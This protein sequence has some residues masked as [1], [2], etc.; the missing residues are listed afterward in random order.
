MVFVTNVFWERIWLHLDVE[1]D[2]SALFAASP[3]FYLVGKG[4]LV[5]TELQATMLDATHAR[6]RMNVT[7]TGVN[8]CVQNGTYKLMAAAS[9]E[10][11]TAAIE[12]A[13]VEDRELLR[14]FRT[15]EE[16]A[17][18]SRNFNYWSNKGTYTVTF[19]LDEYAEEPE[20]QLLF[21]NAETRRVPHVPPRTKPKDRRASGKKPVKGRL[22]DKLSFLKN[23]QQQVYEFLHRT[24]PRGKKRVLFLSEQDDRLALNMQALYDRMKARGLDREL[25]IEFSLRKATSRQYS[26]MSAVKRTRKIARADV[27]L[28][29]D[30]VPLFDKLVLSRD[31]AVIQVWHAGAGFK[32][33]GYSR[34][35]HH[36]CP[37]PFCCHRQYTWCISGSSYIS[38]FFSE[39]F[40]ILDEQIIPTGMPRM[41]RFLDPE[42]RTAVTA[43]IYETYPALQGRKV[44]LF[45]PTYRGRDKAHA[46][47]PYSLI[48]F[49][50]LYR[51]C[52]EED[53]AV[54]FKMHPWV[55]GSVPIPEDFRGRFLDVNGYPDI[56]ELFYV[57]DLLITDY[58]SSMYEFLLMRKPMLFFAYDKNQY[59]NSRGFHRDYDSNVPG[60]ICETFEALMEALERRDFQ[61]E[62]VEEA[63]GRYFDRT[64]TGSCDRVIDWLILDRLPEEYRE[65]LRRKTAE[66]ERVRQMK[67]TPTRSVR[68]R[69]DGRV[70]EDA[71]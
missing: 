40:G 57:T 14:C 11:E 67:L 66:V 39:Q 20:L 37:G 4:G 3:R 34:W 25:E 43:R 50:R 55:S 32:G 28:V 52:C 38:P 12:H 5:E 56:N 15:A 33:V 45:A 69:E 19:M 60:R 30:H 10:V 13:R 54:L 59:A 7:N 21:Y 62:K 48:D 71:N 49:E 65:A 9:F 44:I 17:V 26:A 23:R 18:W 70:P 46:H 51:F 42:N 41:D 16:L 58:S 31:T 35:G 2:R 53:A 36:G 22:K 63:L 8:A 47:Y 1:T 64:D 61:F 68:L 6:L 24:R 29:D 27:I